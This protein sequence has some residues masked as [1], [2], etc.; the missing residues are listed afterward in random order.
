MEATG[1]FAVYSRNPGISETHGCAR[2]PFRLF[3]RQ[4]ETTALCANIGR[5][6][7]RRSISPLPLGRLGVMILNPELA[8]L[9]P[10]R[11]EKQSNDL[12]QD[13]IEDLSQR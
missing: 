10:V 8:Y 6:C 4:L 3:E 9:Q 11:R 13:I 5:E 2:L 7:L 1:S 12:C